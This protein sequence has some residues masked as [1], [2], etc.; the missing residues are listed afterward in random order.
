MGSGGQHLHQPGAFALG[1]RV[2]AGV[3]GAADGRAGGGSS[4]AMARALRVWAGSS[5]AMARALRARAGQRR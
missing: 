5:A 4:A 3:A 1:V 2:G